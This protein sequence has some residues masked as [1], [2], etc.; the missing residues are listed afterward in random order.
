RIGKAIR[1]VAVF[2]CVLGLVAS[3]A[4]SALSSPVADA[5]ADTVMQQA[6]SQSQSLVVASE[7]ARTEIERGDYSATTPEEIAQ[8][9][10][11]EAAKK[12]AAKAAR[13]RP[14]LHQRASL[15]PIA[16]AGQVRYPLVRGTYRV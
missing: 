8:H 15:A 3:V 1:P 2:A 9:K 13:A 6:S 7:T 16:E 14:H 11:Q 4:I 12:A 5:E 10:A